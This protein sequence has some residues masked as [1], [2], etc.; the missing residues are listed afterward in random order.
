MFFFGCDGV[1]V[2]E[3]VVFVD[4]VFVDVVLNDV[5]WLDVSELEDGGLGECIDVIWEV[6][7]YEF[8]MYFVDVIEG[9]IV[10]FVCFWW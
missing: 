10:E 7:V 9:Y 3:D 8:V 6:C 1:L 4:V 5:S 2:V